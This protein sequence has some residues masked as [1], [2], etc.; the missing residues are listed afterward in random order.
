LGVPTGV[1]SPRAVTVTAGVALAMRSISGRSGAALAQAPSRKAAQRPAVDC[2]VME[3]PR[4]R[5][6]LDAL[7]DGAVTEEGE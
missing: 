5:H 6:L 2:L 1:V 4:L 7:Y 3:C